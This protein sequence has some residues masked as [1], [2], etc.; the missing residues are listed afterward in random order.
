MTTLI[1]IPIRPDLHPA[2]R[3]QALH[4]ATALQGDAD[5][6]LDDR[7]WD[8]SVDWPWPER[9]EAQARLRQAVVETALRPHHTAVL[10]VDA[11]VIEYPAT[12]LQSLEALGPE[13]IGAPA[14]LLDRWGERFYDIG[15]FLERREGALA[16]ARMAVPWFDQPGPV[17]ELESV[18][19][20]YRVPADIYREGATHE[21]VRDAASPLGAWSDHFSVCQAALEM[22]RRVRAD[23][24]V[25]A[26]HAW[27]PDFGEG[28]H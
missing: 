27:L 12:L 8:V 26:V 25:K 4:L 1:L 7:P 14:V 3:K 5:L 13:N 21:V 17:V 18:G 28:L 19:C 10:W 9:I 24:S 11:D 23:I 15:G 22:G 6:V 2:L 16:F 20:V